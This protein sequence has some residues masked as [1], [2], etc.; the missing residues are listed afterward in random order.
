MSQSGNDKCA[1]I[2]SL[3]PIRV[4]TICNIYQHKVG[5]REIASKLVRCD[6]FLAVTMNTAVFWIWRRIVGWACTDVLWGVVYC[7]W[8]QHVPL[9]RQYARRHI[10][11]KLYSLRRMFVSDGEHIESVWWPGYWLAGRGTLVR[12]PV[13]VNGFISSILLQFRHWGPPSL[14]LSVYGEIF[15]WSK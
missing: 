6:V 1:R 10:F 15:F 4:K 13:V 8:R 7:W 2:F 3:Q 12:F 9:L 5:R 11:E 14:L